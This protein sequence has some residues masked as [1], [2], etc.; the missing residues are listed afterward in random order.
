MIDSGSEFRFFA[1]NFISGETKIRNP[2]FK[3]IDHFRKTG[4]VEL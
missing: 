2:K 1:K 4:A 3:M